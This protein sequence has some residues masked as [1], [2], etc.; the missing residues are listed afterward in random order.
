M[1]SI[2]FGLNKLTSV[3]LQKSVFERL[4][5]WSENIMNQQMKTAL[6]EILDSSE[7]YSDYTKSLLKKKLTL[8]K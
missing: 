6:K 1:K 3:E 4:V 7:D 2:R 5:M 8:I